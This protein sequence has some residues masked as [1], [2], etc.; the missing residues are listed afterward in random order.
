[1]P[2]HPPEAKALARAL[3]VQ[4]LKYYAISIHTQVKESVIRSW[5]KRGN[6][7]SL[8]AN[9]L[10]NVPV[11]LQRGVAVDTANNLQ[12]RGNEIREKLSQ[13]L[14]AQATLLASTPPGSVAELG[15]SKH[16]QG[17]ASIAK[18]IA[19]AA[20]IVHDWGNQ[21]QAGLVLIGE[22]SR[23]PDEP[24]ALDI[25]ATVTQ[26]PEPEPDTTTDSVPPDAQTLSEGK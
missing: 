18:T 20:G 6:W 16:G 13:E 9:P 10:R 12:S 19:D 14:M 11:V 26:A 8:V 23:A 7:A 21:G 24:A 4:G 3:Y 1:M 17:R 15:N 2:R 5:A 25:G 22:L